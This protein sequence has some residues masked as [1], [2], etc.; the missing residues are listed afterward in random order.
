VLHIWNVKFPSPPN[1]LG[2]VSHLYDSYSVGIRVLFCPA[3][4][5]DRDIQGG[6]AGLFTVGRYTGTFRRK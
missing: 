2:G 3:E 4:K 6:L 1:N 5:F